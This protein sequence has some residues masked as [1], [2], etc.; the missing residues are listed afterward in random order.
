MTLEEYMEQE[1]PGT[2]WSMLDQL[3]WQAA[4]E[5]TK[6][7]CAE[8]LCAECKKFTPGKAEHYDGEKCGEY[9]AIMEVE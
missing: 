6:K 9:K 3:I 8:A 1:H 2:G 7:R 4:V 5:D